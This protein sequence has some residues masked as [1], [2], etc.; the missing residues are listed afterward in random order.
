ME[1]LPINFLIKD[2][3]ASI[4]IVDPNMHFI[5]HSKTWLNDFA[6]GHSSII[7]QSY[8][9]VIPDT[10]KELKRIHKECLEGKP[11][12]N[13]GYKLIHP[14]GAVQWLKW[15][16]NAWREE[17][18]TVGG[19]IIV[20]ED[21][22]EEKR[23]Q[24]LLMKAKSVARIGGWE[25][26]MVANKLYWTQV[27]REIHEVPTDYVPNL[28]E[29]IN[30]YKQGKSRDTI[31]LLVSRAMKDGTPWDTELQIVTAKGRELWVRAKGEAEVINGKC[32]RIYGTFQDI[33]ESKRTALEYQKVSDRLAIA[34]SAAKIGIWDYNVV[35]NILVWDD[36]M[37]DL[38]GVAQKDFIG[39]FE[40][41]EACVHPDDKG[42]SL[43][44]LDMALAGVKEFNTEF[45][46][47]LSDGEIKHIKAKSTVK[48]D[49]EG[50]P[51]RMIGANWDITKLK[52]TQLELL[53][54]QESFEG[55]FENSAVG[56]AIVGLD[57]KWI[58][59]NKS[60]CKSLG[61]RKSELLKLTFQDITHPDD[62]DI[63][64]KLLRKLIDGKRKSYQIEKRYFHKN[65]SI[66]S[67]VL[68]VTAVKNIKGELSHFISQI[69]D[70]S[71]RIEVQ[72]KLTKLLDVTSE[73]NDSL[74]NFA[75]IVSHNLRSH[76]SN[77]SMLAG[78]LNKEE[79]EEEQRNL[80]GM[81]LDASESLNETVLHLN[82]VVQVKAG[83]LEEMI[84]VNLFK[85][86]K[87][88]KKNL[89]VLLRE[90][91]ARCS[92]D[93]PTT[94]DIIGIP[95]YLDS[96]FLNLFTNSIKYS[97]PER[98]LILKITASKIDDTIQVSFS[99]NGLGIDLDK[100]GDKLFGMY[101]TFH[102]HKDAKGIGLFITK[103]QIE[104]MNGRIEVKSKVGIGT[105]FKIFFQVN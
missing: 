44:E 30:F 71:S 79:N 19:L 56:M 21:I 2:S 91:K 3:P 92:I 87:D 52:N 74:L 26:D 5:S 99:D 8:Y 101:K 38:Y 17:N 96:I 83:A 22:T 35:D 39:A 1:T 49:E 13:T 41:W 73:Q 82:D 95:A 75:H 9:D 23:S 61:Y 51:L 89:G 50:N 60:L 69:V 62:L 67:A 16:I 85:T 15:K 6:N 43:K 84:P 78:F 37:Y 65:G 29:G 14:N 34:T 94:L 66:V 76:S 72:D 7:G 77:L 48:R 32:I 24:E 20:Q 45:R 68:T 40:A 93:V 104:A 86:I 100:H 46:V 25:M 36:N 47:V 103:N 4:A 53:R 18:E 64:L 58:Q 81:L 98:G 59:V 42:K 90:K 11:N 27:T 80:I 55:A 70:I 10:P 33:D 105:T 12:V 102:K 54:S 31:T 57:G 88:V 63:D 97:S 28:E